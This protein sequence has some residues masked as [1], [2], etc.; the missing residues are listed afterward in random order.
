MTVAGMTKL[1]ALVRTQEGLRLNAY[2]NPGDEWTIGY[3]H[4]LEAHGFTAAQAASTGWTRERCE[5]ALLSDIQAATVTVF[6]RWPWVETLADA[7][8][9]VLIDMAFQMGVDGLG[10]FRNTLAAI[11]SGLYEIA[12]NDMLAS[13]WARET[14]VRAQIEALMMRTGVWPGESAA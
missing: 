3:G 10:K 13:N 4:N 7:R 5:S 2:C 11:Q 9:G 12:A 8:Q 14:P 6:A 1:L